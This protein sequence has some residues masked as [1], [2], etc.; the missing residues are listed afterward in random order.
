MRLSLTDGRPPAAVVLVGL[1]L[2]WGAGFP[3]VELVVTELPPLAAA[4]IRYGVAGVAVLGYAVASGG[5]IRPPDRRTAVGVGL[6]GAFT[7]CGYQ[8]GLYLGTQYVSG[9]VAAVVTTTSPVLAAVLA[10]PVF[11]ESRG[12]PDALG[13]VVGVAGVVVL[14][15]PTAIDAVGV[16]TDPTAS[17]VGQTTVGVALVFGG[18]ALFAAGSLAIQAFGGGLSTPA[19]QG[20][21]MVVGA[22]LLVVASLARGESLPPAA[23][24]SPQALLALVY[25]TVV[26]GT[27]GYLVYFRLVER[28]GATETTLVAYLEPVGATLVAV[29]LLGQTVDARTVTGSLAVAAGFTLVSRRTL[30][31]AVVAARGGGEVSGGEGATEER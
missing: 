4:A 25:V 16:L 12:W 21:A 26:A 17:G 30:R 2:L 20:E 18:T 5:R 23:A 29:T 9:A 11:G 14:A 22:A 13:F 7:F 28:V 6:V 1:G 27:L 10:V 3:A 31:R 24:V 15:D 19:F 8:G